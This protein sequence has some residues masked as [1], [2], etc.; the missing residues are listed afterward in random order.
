MLREAAQ[1]ITHICIDQGMYGCGAAGVR[2]FL[3]GSEAPAWHVPKGAAMSTKHLLAWLTSA[4]MFLA[5]L[6]FGRAQASPAVAEPFRAY[7]EQHQGLRVLGY[8]MTGL[9]ETNGYLSQYFEK[10]R[11]EDH[12]AEP[13]DAAWDFMYGRLAAE[14]IEQAG[15]TSISG[16]ALSYADLGRK[17]QSSLHP[18][19]ND[20]AGGVAATPSG[21]FVP[22]DAQLRP[23]YGYV[24]P[25]YFWDYITQAALFPGGWL[26]DIGLPMT[27]AFQSDAYKN[28]KLRKI[29]VQA[30]ERTVL[31]Y[32]AQNS[33]AWQVERA[34]IGADAVQMLPAPNTIELPAP[35]ARVTLPI[36]ILA[37]VGR[38]GEIVSVHLFWEHGASLAQPYTLLRGEDG[39]AVL[40]TT[41]DIPPE[42][43][44]Q[45]P[46][47]QAAQLEI[48]SNQGSVL[49]RQAVTVLHPDDP[50]TRQ[51]TLYWTTTTSIEAQAQPIPVS[52]TPAA[53]ALDLLLWGPRAQTPMRLTTALPTPEEVLAFPGRTAD[54]GP[55]VTLR[56]LT[57]GDGSAVADFSKE[58]AAYGGDSSR[59]SLIHAQITRTLLEFPGIRDVQITVNGRRDHLLEP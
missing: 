18:A 30:F 49:A 37:R 9:V 31:T 39:R 36:H 42:Y 8:P 48:D 59:A 13:N 15:A 38:P 29:T 26:H 47:T 24:V 57:L 56:S 41:L 20:F 21:T 35:N 16:T 19:P 2:I 4:A 45:H 33:I 43:R 46:W 3:S 17:H 10:G 55:R 5:F 44:S 54:W 51:A 22:Y 25:A 50:D 53:A 34:N 23:A 1:C 7:Y 12:N 28:G 11:L 40:I 58:L 27:D 14:L 32:D 6:P 52:S